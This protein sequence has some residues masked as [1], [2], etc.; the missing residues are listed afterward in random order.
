MNVDRLKSFASEKALSGHA[1]VTRALGTEILSGEYKPGANLPAEAEL[2]ARFQI[3]RTVLREV[4]KT[5][6]AKGLIASKTRVGTRVLDPSRWNYFDPDILAWK[7]SL[8]LDAAFRT[9]L[10]EIRQAIEPLAAALASQRRTV[11]QIRELRALV[12]EMAAPDHSRHSFAEADLRF[13]LAIGGASGNPMIRSIGAV[14]EAALAASFSL[15]SPT[16]DRKQQEKTVAMHDAIVD[17]IEAKDPGAARQAMLAVIDAGVRRI[18]SAS[19][20]RK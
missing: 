10:T 15:S 4:L 18:A 7:V 6:A 13:H 12:Q 16:D 11:A 8:G 3:S 20:A 9:N 1:Q 5:L 14:I 2:L 19:K 17:A